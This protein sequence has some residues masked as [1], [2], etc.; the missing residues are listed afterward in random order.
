MKKED[1]VSKAH[2][3]LVK[4]GRKSSKCWIGVDLDGT[5]A[6]LQGFNGMKK[7][8][9][10]IPLMVERVKGWVAEGLTVKIFT[11]RVSC[12]GYDEQA[13]RKFFRENG[14]PENLEITNVKDMWMSA[15]WDDIAVQVE[16]NTGR[17]VDGKS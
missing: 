5:L 11:A 7:V 4:R 17:R 13:I 15:L 14:L 12:V 9:K 2:Y 16:P 6:E 10:P 8:G 3:L 1:T